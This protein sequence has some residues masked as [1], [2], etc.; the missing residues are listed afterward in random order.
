MTTTNESGI[1]PVE[2]NV[3]VKPIEVEEKTAGGLIL[4]DAKIEQD[5]FSRTEGTLIA[6]S[7]M[8]FE[9]PDWPAHLEDEK[10]QVSDRVVFSRYQATE[11]K[12]ADGD[13]F[14]LMK[15]TAIAGVMS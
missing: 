2:Y 7:P 9:N 3:V 11:I 14:W 5:S 4:P 13:K 10:P 15:D 8:A 1:R 12:N 6:V